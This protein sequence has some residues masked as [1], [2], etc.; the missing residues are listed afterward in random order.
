MI[1]ACAPQVSQETRT[2]HQALGCLA[3]ELFFTFVVKKTGKY[4]KIETRSYAVLRRGQ[5]Q[6]GSQQENTQS[7]P[8]AVLRMVLLPGLPA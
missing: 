6:S 4:H 3:P 1:M 7:S 8:T 5:S 2:A